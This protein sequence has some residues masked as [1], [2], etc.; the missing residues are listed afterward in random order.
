MGD[1]QRGPG[2]PAG[3]GAEDDHTNIQASLSAL[4]G[5]PRLLARAIQPDAPFAA[6]TASPGE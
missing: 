5:T 6:V 4:G 2:A 3:P 1:D